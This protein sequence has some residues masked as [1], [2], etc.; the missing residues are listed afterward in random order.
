MHIQPFPLG[1]LSVCY[2]P[3]L[4]A[5]LLPFCINHHAQQLYCAQLR[6]LQVMP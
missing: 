2:V 1:L 4:I 6:L 3:E 5:Q